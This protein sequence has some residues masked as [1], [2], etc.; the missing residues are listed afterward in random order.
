MRTINV[1]DTTIPVITLI[2]ASNET[3]EVHSTYVDPGVYACM[4]NYDGDISNNVIVTNNVNTT[5]LG[6]YTIEYNVTD[7]NGNTAIPIIR[8]VNM[9]QLFML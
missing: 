6:T 4:Y 9:K 1:V 8:T 7:S 3:I 2:G 5:I